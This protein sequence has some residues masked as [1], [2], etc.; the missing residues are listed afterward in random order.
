MRLD[1][2]RSI[3][4][5]PYLYLGPYALLFFL[6]IMLPILSAIALGLTDF[7]SFQRPGFVGTRNFVYMFTQDDVF[8]QYVLPNTLKFAVIVGPIGFILAFLLAYLLAQISSKPRTILALLIYSPSMTSA[9]AMQ[10]I[11]TTIFSGNQSGYLN[12]FLLQRGWIVEPLQWLQDPQYLFTIMVVVSLW[13]SMGIGF[14]AMLAGMLNIN[15][16]MYEAAYIDGM[17]NRFQEITRI[18][19]PSMKPQMLFGAVMAILETF[20]MGAIGVELS[21]ANPTPQYSGQL[22]IN[23]IDDYGFMRYEMGYAAA[24]AVLLLLFIYLTSRFVWRLFGEEAEVE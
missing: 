14:L 11:W 21:G 18:T 15:P 10:V 20:Q 13:N 5:N 6:F 8:M 22:M 3:I 12:A 9:V 16:E 19:I 7:N 2:N 23:H 1:G 4:N 17:S 24:L